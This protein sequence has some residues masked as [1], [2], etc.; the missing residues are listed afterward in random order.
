MLKSTTCLLNQIHS[1][2]TRFKMQKNFLTIS[3]LQ[4]MSWAGILTNSHVFFT[5]VYKVQLK[6]GSNNLTLT[7]AQI[8]KKIFSAFLLR[9]KPLGQDWSREACFLSLRQMPQENSQQFANRVLKKGTKIGKQDKDHIIQFIRDLPTPNRIHTIAQGTF[10]SAT[11][12]AT[13]FE[14]A[15]TF[16]QDDSIVTLQQQGTSLNFKMV[17]SRIQCAHCKKDD[18]HISECHNRKS[19]NLRQHPYSIQRNRIQ[20]SPPQKGP[21][22]G[23]TSKPRICV[24]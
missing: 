7:P 4:L 16:G 24:L 14:T 1:E 21:T 23:Q 5:C 12:I 15:Q 20:S 2:A 13:L 9:F 19:S 8:L 11:R 6:Y 3:N 17:A 18:K 10:D 22:N